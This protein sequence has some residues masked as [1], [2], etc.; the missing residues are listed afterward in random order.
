MASI[1]EV[2]R[3]L[4]SK[5]AAPQCSVGDLSVIPSNVFG[6]D[7]N[8]VYH[9]FCKKWKKENESS[10]K[11]DAAGQPVSRKTESF[12]KSVQPR[13]PPPDP[14]V[15]S[16]YDFDLNFVGLENTDCTMDCEEA[17]S[18][19]TRG[20]SNTGSKLLRY[21][22]CRP[23]LRLT[24]HG[25]QEYRHDPVGYSKCR[26]WTV[27]IPD[28]LHRSSARSVQPTLLRGGR[29]WR[30]WRYRKTRGFKSRWGS[31]HSIVN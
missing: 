6:S 31:L 18:A 25:S 27:R 10:M 2:Y 29:V 12:S 8:N 16:N 17:F 5:P 22:S 3:K 20:C 21:H 26:L 9:E 4:Q 24:T 7:K 11:V 15:W 23:K 13:T 14:K 30:P 19:L 1:A 28:Q